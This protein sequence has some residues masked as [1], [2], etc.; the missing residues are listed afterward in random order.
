MSEGAPVAVVGAGIVGAACARALQRAGHKVIL[1]DATEPG[2]GTSFGN[3][4]YVAVD[5]V[6]PLCRPDIL[7]KVPRM[8][9]ERDAPL[10]IRW[11]SLPWILPWMAR[12]AIAARPDQLARGI[13]ALGALVADADAAWQ[14]ELQAS[15]LADLF[16]QRGGLYVYETERQFQADA[17]ER[18][19]QRERGMEF[20]ILDGAGAR[21]I[22]PGL[23]PA[24]IRA[25]HFPRTMH[26]LNPQ[27]L[28]RSLVER[29]VA[30][31]GRF[32]QARVETFELTGARV[33]GVV[34]L[35][36]RFPVG[37][38]VLAAGR[39]SSELAALLRFRAPLIAERGYHVMLEGSGHACE[40]PVCSAERGFFVT[41]MEEGVRLA[42]TVELS[43]A[44]APPS[45]ARAEVL[46]RQARAIFP[47]IDDRMVSQWMG[48]RPTLPDFL[49]AIGR[50]P[51]LANVYC[52]YGHQHLG[53]TL[54]AETGRLVTRLLAGEALTPAVRA[55]DPGRFG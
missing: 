23:S 29:F 24:I 27:R 54:A 3:A 18:R 6:M 37:A 5:H 45:W 36:E 26:T 12:F 15:G 40:V 10:N 43:H 49:P 30:D 1:L 39:A 48:E 31:G 28:V 52:A 11:R 33:G 14:I 44:G 35:R 4:G 19:L 41:P 20:A 53:L 25:V 47:A 13:D 55:C 16:R 21:E 8:L 7:L 50:A 9:V 22:A 46:R 17:Q 2:Q 34:T 38:L 32:E 51:D 42:G